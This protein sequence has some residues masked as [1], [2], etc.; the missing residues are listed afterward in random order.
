MVRPIA[1]EAAALMDR[2]RERALG[3]LQKPVKELVSSLLTY[4][5]PTLSPTQIDVVLAELES[6]GSPHPPAK[7]PRK[8]SPKKP[9]QIGNYAQKMIVLQVAYF[10]SG[11]LGFAVQSQRELETIEGSLIHAL[12][13][14]RLVDPKAASKDFLWS[15]CGRTDKD[16]SA[17]ANA[18][19]LQ[20]RVVPDYAKILNRALPAHIQVIGEADAPKLKDFSVRFNCVSRT[21]KYLMFQDG[22][23]VERMQHAAALFV[24]KHDFRNFCKVEAV[25]AATRTSWERNVEKVDLV[26]RKDGMIEFTIKAEGFLYHQIRCI[27]SILLLIG[28]GKEEPSLISELL[29]V[30]KHPRKPVYDLADPLPLI[31]YDC[32]ISTE[33]ENQNLKFHLSEEAGRIVMENFTK[34]L[35][36]LTVKKEIAQ[37]QIA[38]LQET[39]SV[40]VEFQQLAV[41]R[42]VAYVPILDR[43]AGK[44]LEEM[45]ALYEGNKVID[46]DLD[47]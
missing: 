6:G 24:G 11:T 16:V 19:A 3:L 20:A 28:H 40:H 46:E 15:K 35:R 1:P 14:T 23:D 41:P 32:E 43:P 26:Q 30:I 9:F 31:F 37:T 25:T 5:F 21:Y 17:A 2:W 4:E 10:G 38:R 13:H 42:N 7:K 39:L 36:E 18:V 33:I 45:A 12:R 44:T 8:S 29:N 22:V 34:R 47:D 27:V